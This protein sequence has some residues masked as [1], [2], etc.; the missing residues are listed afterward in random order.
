MK[1]LIKALRPYW[2]LIPTVLVV[3]GAIYAEGVNNTRVSYGIERN[4]E[5]IEQLEGSM[6]K[7]CSKVDSVLHLQMIQYISDSIKNETSVNRAKDI[8]NFRAQSNP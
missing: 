6:G 5:R 3:V 4:Q 2:F 8:I 1:R 7:I